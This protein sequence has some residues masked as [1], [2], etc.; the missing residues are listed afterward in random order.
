[1]YCNYC[2]EKLGENNNQVIIKNKYYH[3]KCY[4]IMI[5]MPLEVDEEELEDIF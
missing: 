5:D 3:L 1:V 4:H 2:K